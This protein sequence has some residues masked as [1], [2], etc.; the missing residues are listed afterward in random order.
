M[1]RHPYDTVV[2]NNSIASISSYAT[3]NGNEEKGGGDIILPMPILYENSNEN[4]IS[5]EQVPK[6]HYA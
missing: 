2:R 6:K 5:C 1:L 3:S 4:E